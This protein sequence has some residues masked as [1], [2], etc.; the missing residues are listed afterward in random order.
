MPHADFW[1]KLADKYA[2]QPVGNPEAYAET[3]DRVRGFCNKDTRFLELGC[4]TGTTALI[5]AEYVATYRGTDFAE[6]MI[7]IARAKL[8]EDPQPNLSFDVVDAEGALSGEADVIFASSL[9]HL[10]P[11]PENLISKIYEDLPSGGY[12]LSK[13]VCLGQKQ[14]Y[15][16]PVI[17][18]MRLIG[19][20]PFV[21]F[22]SF[23][24]VNDMLR[25]AGF[26]I[27]ETALLPAP[28]AHFAV[29]RKP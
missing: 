16:K 15:L 12:F 4:G 23:E 20:A 1:T 21:N 5:L 13:T 24:D 6:G 7:N 29:A 22:L 25:K 9:L 18:L 19:K 8:E 26:D 11:D 10:M 2:S 14:R 28:N 27:L 3:L 17:A